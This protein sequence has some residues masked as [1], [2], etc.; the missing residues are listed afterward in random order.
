[1][2]R[3]EKC[4]ERGHSLHPPGAGARGAR[5][6][7]GGHDG[8]L[9]ALL[10]LEHVLGGEAPRAEPRHPGLRRPHARRDYALVT[11]VPAVARGPAEPVG[12]GAH[13]LAG[14]GR[15]RPPGRLLQVNRAVRKPGHLGG[16]RERRRGSLVRASATRAST[17]GGAGLARRRG[18]QP[19]S[20][21]GSPRRARPSVTA[22]TRLASRSA[23]TEMWVRRL[24]RE[25]SSTPTRATPEWSAACLASATARRR[26]AHARP[27]ASRRRGVTA[28]AVAL[29][30]T[31]AITCAS[32]RAARCEFGRTSQGVRTVRTPCSGQ[33]A[34][35]TAQWCVLS[36]GSERKSHRELSSSRTEPGAGF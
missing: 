17:S 14:D 29:G 9:D 5:L 28:E 35:G 13:G 36:T 4:P 11:A 16:Q 21:I 26:T 24:A 27:S 20:A 6:G 34:R 12:L 33:S 23:I 8:P 3:P 15:G 18:R 32:K 10:A 22:T 31:A 25:V 1:M 30:M 7:H 19:L 2:T